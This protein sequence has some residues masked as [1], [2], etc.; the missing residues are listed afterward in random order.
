MRQYHDLETKHSMY[1]ERL[2]GHLRARQKPGINPNNKQKLLGRN[3]STRIFEND[4]NPLVQQNLG[5][6]GPD[7]KIRYHQTI[8]D[9]DEKPTVHMPRYQQYGD[10]NNGSSSSLPRNQ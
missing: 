8:E 4:R 2:E 6:I 3:K 7:G 10:H 9:V 5:E 1:Q